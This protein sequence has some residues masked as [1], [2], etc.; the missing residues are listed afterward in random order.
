VNPLIASADGVI[1]ADA[2]VLI[3]PGRSA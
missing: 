3:E 2:R 1:A